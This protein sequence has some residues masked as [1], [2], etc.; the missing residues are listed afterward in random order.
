MSTKRMIPTA[1]WLDPIGSLSESVEEQI[2]RER[3]FFEEELGVKLDV[4]TPQNVHQIQV[5][6][7]L[8]L[9]DWGGAH[10]SGKDHSRDLLRW[11]EDNPSSLV[12]VISDFTYD[13]AFRIA[14]AEALSEAG[15]A[16][17][18]VSASWSKSAGDRYKTP[19][20]NVVVEHALENFIPA[21]FRKSVGAD[22][23]TGSLE[24]ICAVIPVRQPKRKRK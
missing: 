7:E 17:V 1:I 4:H 19:I 11:A 6:T 18:A 14:I 2:E 21:W 8:V 12:V 10:F 15:E 16:D 23:W 22:S 20:H 9:F 24:S 5:G 13:R 3:E